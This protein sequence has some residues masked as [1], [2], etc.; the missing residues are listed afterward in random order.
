MAP[1]HHKN[2]VNSISQPHLKA[3]VCFWVGELCQSLEKKQ[4]AS[5]YIGMMAIDII[6]GW[7]QEE[8]LYLVMFF[9]ETRYSSKE[10]QSQHD[11]H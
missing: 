1:D 10:L 11:N 3:K 2:P 9:V 8:F 7:I 4:D 5:G 6:H